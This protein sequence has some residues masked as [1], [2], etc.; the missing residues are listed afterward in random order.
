ME[1]AKYKNL[2]DI[3]H[4]EYSDK[5]LEATAWKK[6]SENTGLDIATCTKHWA[7]LKR[8]ANYHIKPQRIPFKSGAG[9]NDKEVEQKYRD[10]CEFFD[11]ISFYTPPSLKKPESLVSFL[12]QPGKSTDQDFLVEETTTSTMVSENSANIESVYLRY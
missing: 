2:Y 6:V 7:S 5:R 11:I 9:A 4:A 1:V 8:S 10:D 12:N 3:S